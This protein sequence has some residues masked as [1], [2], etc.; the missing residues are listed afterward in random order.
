MDMSKIFF[1]VLFILCAAAFSVTLFNTLTADAGT[2]QGVVGVAAPIR[3][4]VRA[5]APMIPAHIDI[6]GLGVSAEVQQVGIAASGRMAT[7][8]SF[9]DA[10]WYKYGSAPG[11]EGS[12]VI[13]GHLDNA[14]GMPGVFGS[15][16]KIEVGDEVLIEN[17]AGR[18]LRFEVVKKEI[19]AY[20]STDTEE[21]F[22]ATGEPQLVLIT[23]EGEWDQ[24]LKQ[25]KG[26]LA[27]FAT[28]VR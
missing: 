8:G 25:Y 17:A 1:T 12:A 14:L 16:H 5:A 27:V 6:P 4:V 23:C 7:I 9:S 28:L 22:T 2:E 11:E 24:K 15:L 26:R 3:T 20:D 10:A 18:T 19:I 21:I 13:A